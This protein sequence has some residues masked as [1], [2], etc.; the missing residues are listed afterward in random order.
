[1][2]IA[3]V[4]TVAGKPA[5][6]VA[7]YTVA[8]T[9]SAGTGRILVIGVV[10]VTNTFTAP[11]VS[12]ITDNKSN[13]WTEV[14]GATIINGGASSAGAIWYAPISTSGATT[15]TITHTG[16]AQRNSICWVREY[17]GLATSTVLDNATSAAG[18]SSTPSSGATATTVQA[19]E[20][21]IGV[22]SSAAGSSAW[23][24]GTGFGNLVS[25]VATSF[26]C[27]GAME[28]KIVAATGAQTATF[29][30][31]ASGLWTGSVATFKD[32]GGSAA[33]TV[34]KTPRR[35]RARHIRAA[36]W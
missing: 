26:T 22:G 17:S 8:I 36:Y 9:T 35:N 33:V 27:D 4:Q 32:A 12:T 30:S 15:I 28:D 16:T 10:G 24:A 6:D 11:A 2:A 1:M 3:L 25:D 14:S 31:P 29:T 7:S 13:T 19:D 20:L 21:I 34:S 23:T 5:S 18:N